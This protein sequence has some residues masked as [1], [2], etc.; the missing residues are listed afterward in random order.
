MRTRLMVV[1]V[2]T[3]L[4]LGLA[5]TAGAGLVTIADSQG[6]FSSTQGQDNWYYGY[7]AESGGY[8]PANFVEM[9]LFEVGSRWTEAGGR[10]NPW[11]TYHSSTLSHPGTAAS[12]HHWAVRRWISEVDAT[13]TIS[14]IV[15]RSTFDGDYRSDGITA[16]LV[17]DGTTV[18][19]WTRSKTQQDAINYS[20]DVPVSIGSKVDLV[21]DPNN[22]DRSDTTYFTA[23]VQYEPPVT[24][25]PEPTSLGL[26]GLAALGLRKRRR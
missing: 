14:G 7:W 18:G 16:Y 5:G 22:Y 4:V 20:L 26:L 24:A 23:M 21:L 2:V 9:P 6:E 8:N 3:A 17:V 12:P 15:R 25:V 11:W 19:T 10:S 1:A 13:V